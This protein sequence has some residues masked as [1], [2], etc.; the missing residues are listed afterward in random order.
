MNRKE[1]KVKIVIFLF[2]SA[3]QND[4]VKENQNAPKDS[5]KISKQDKIESN[6]N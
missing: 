2:F 6:R 4:T 5:P 1:K 3:D